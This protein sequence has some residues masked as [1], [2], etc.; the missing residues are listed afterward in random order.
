[1]PRRGLESRAAPQQEWKVLVRI[2]RRDRLHRPAQRG[3]QECHGLR[4][5]EEPDVRHLP[6][7]VPSPPET[8]YAVARNQ[9]SRARSLAPSVLAG[10]H[11][12]VGRAEKHVHTGVRQSRQ[13]VPIRLE[14]GSQRRIGLR[15]RVPRVLQ[16]RNPGPRAIHRRQARQ[17]ANNMMGDP[18]QS[19]A[20][21][22]HARGKGIIWKQIQQ[23]RNPGY[24]YIESLRRCQRRS[25]IGR[26]HQYRAPQT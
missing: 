23:V 11:Q 26:C 3:C 22:F 14:V 24:K 2:E 10:H 17:R 6:L 18:P 9:R 7:Q 13:Q 20:H 8:P 19:F 5:V 16:V 1:M 4:F 15:G 25:G 21:E 12:V